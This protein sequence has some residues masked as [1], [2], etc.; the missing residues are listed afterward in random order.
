MII[1]I[2]FTLNDFKT[3]VQEIH[4]SRDMRSSEDVKVPELYL[5]T[6][7]YECNTFLGHIVL[8]IHLTLEPQEKNFNFSTALKK[9]RA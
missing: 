1:L 8:L 6:T 4:Y 2:A 5:S 3:C 9:T 7:N